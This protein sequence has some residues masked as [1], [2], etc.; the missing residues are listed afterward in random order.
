MGAHILT[1]I[2]V[3]D[4]VWT[5]SRMTS[6]MVCTEGNRVVCCLPYTHCLKA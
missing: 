6:W 3:L 5:V 1:S 2:V 4:P